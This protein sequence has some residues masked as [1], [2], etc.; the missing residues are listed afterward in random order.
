MPL[1]RSARRLT[2][3]FSCQRVTLPQMKA[4]RAAQVSGQRKAAKGNTAKATERK[5]KAVKNEG[6]R[7]LSKKAANKKANLSFKSGGMNKHLKQC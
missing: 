4:M 5:N 2:T 3:P 1:S 6:S 7:N